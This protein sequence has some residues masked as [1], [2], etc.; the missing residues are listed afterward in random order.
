MVRRPRASEN[1][2]RDPESALR[3][4]MCG[5][6][7]ARYDVRFGMS[8]LRGAGVVLRGGQ[9]GARASHESCGPIYPRVRGASERMVLTPRL[10]FVPERVVLTP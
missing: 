7:F 10:L 6:R 8:A 9:R 1:A 4:E 5:Q 3:V 2:S